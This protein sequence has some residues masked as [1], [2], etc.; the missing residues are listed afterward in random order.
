MSSSARTSNFEAAFDNSKDLPPMARYPR[1][2]Q[3]RHSI[4]TSV[5]NKQVV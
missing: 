5:S 4:S 2:T 1:L 3:K